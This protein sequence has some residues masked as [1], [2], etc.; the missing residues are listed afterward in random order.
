MRDVE[1]SDP[2]WLT[3]PQRET[4]PSWSSEHIHH[5][6]PALPS[7]T[8]VKMQDCSSKSLRYGDFFFHSDIL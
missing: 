3:N 4:L 6:N 1:L 7:N 8:P 5:I 2:S